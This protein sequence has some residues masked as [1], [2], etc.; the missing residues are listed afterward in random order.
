MY[1]RHEYKCLIQE[2]EV[3]LLKRRL[4]PLVARDAHVDEQGG[5][6]IR[7]LYF[8]DAAF[9]A[10]HDKQDGVAEREKYRVRLYNYD[11][12]VVHLE[13]KEKLHSY[14]HKDSERLTPE[15]L[16]S[17]LTCEDAALVQS[18]KK[19]LRRFGLACRLKLLR[20]IQLVDYYR[21]AFVV[22]NGNVRITFDRLLTAPLA[23]TTMT[24][25]DAPSMAALPGGLVIMEIK[26]DGYIPHHIGKLLRINGRERQAAS[27][28]ILC[29]AA[30]R[31]MK[32]SYA[33]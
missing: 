28:Y 16:H 13:R 5:Y 24:A 2:S 3:M 30:A 25:R 22:P 4:E 14:I 1:Y 32:E 31:R 29:C 23:F 33:L 7:S 11:D 9:S 18:D 27:K 12:S 26:Y 21:E 10:F 6:W 8:D 19:L 15:E 17:V 20:P